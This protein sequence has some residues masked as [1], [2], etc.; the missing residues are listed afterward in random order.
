MEHKKQWINST[1][2]LSASQWPN[3]P[4]LC[5][6]VA[7]QECL[8]RDSPK[9]WDGFSEIQ[10]SAFA[11]PPPMYT[12]NREM[13][14]SVVTAVSLTPNLALLPQGHLCEPGCIPIPSKMDF[15][16]QEAK[17]NE[18]QREWGKQMRS[19]QQP[20][21]YFLLKETTQVRS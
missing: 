6:T 18:A 9:F 1:F 4:L 3:F 17:G 2:Q 21:Q 14:D 10:G 8:P 13:S 7:I 12:K 5:A 11:E 19:A 20:T 16:L 15:L